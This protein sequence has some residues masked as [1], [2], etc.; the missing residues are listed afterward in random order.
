MSLSPAGGFTTIWAW[1]SPLTST[2]TS[3]SALAKTPRPMDSTAWK[4]KPCASRHFASFEVIP[5]IRAGKL[6]DPGSGKYSPSNSPCSSSKASVRTRSASWAS[7]GDMSCGGL[8]PLRF[9]HNW[10]GFVTVP[11]KSPS[12]SLSK[13]TL[14]S[15]QNSPNNEVISSTG[16]SAL[17][18]LNTVTR[19]STWMFPTPSP[20]IVL[21]S[22]LISN[23]DLSM[24][25]SIQRNAICKLAWDQR[26]GQ[27]SFGT[28]LPEAM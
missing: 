3:N 28:Q 7:S 12:T 11:Q 2:A 1:L 9:R 4:S 18:F 23:C 20:S 27:M 21:S 24:L 14:P 10:A 17:S 5:P 8:I 25:L 13:H 22:F 16:R 15:E 6:C 26:N 19:S